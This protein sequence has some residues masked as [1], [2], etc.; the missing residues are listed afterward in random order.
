M[1]WGPTPIA[2]PETLTF[3]VT[4]TRAELD[5]LSRACRKRG[6]AILCGLDTLD[7]TDAV[8]SKI[9]DAARKAAGVKD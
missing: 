6:L 8:L 9:T 3:T 1:S 7:D 5:G 2:W 4:L